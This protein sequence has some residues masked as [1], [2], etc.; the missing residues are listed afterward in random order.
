MGMKMSL[1]IL[2]SSIKKEYVLIYLHFFVN[3]SKAFD[4]GGT[5]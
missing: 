2:A 1:G 5:P 4:T 3:E